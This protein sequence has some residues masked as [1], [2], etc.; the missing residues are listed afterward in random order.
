MRQRLSDMSDPNY[1]KFCQDAGQSS[2]LPKFFRIFRYDAA[3]RK[4]ASV[5]ENCTQ[6]SHF[7][8]SCEK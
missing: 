4:R 6:I 3:F 5:V 7:L 1:T 8:T 2:M